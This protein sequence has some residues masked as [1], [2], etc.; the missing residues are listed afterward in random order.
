VTVLAVVAIGVALALGLDVLRYGGPLAWLVAHAPGPAVYEAR[1]RTFDVDGRP[2]YLD[3]R[4]SGSPTVILEAGFGANAGNWSQQLQDIEPLTRVCAWDR[5]G[6][7]RSAPRG[8]HTGLEA[9]ADLRAVLAAAGEHGPYVVVAHSLGGVYGLLFESVE[10]SAGGDGV[11]GFVMLDTF[12]PLAWMAED[13]LLDASIRA[14]H[15]EV[16]AQTGAMIEGGE[17]LDFDATIAEL[18]ALPPTQTETLL[19]PIT[20]DRKFGDQSQPG[21]AALAASWYRVVA[22]HYP[23]GRVEV[24]ADSGHA[25]GADQP[26]LVADR[27]RAMVEAIRSR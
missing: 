10:A 18:L 6:V 8:L 21:P 15:R 20:M 13:P 14:N 11:A 12:E 17:Q 22:E 9:A 16:F 24:V 26:Q 2:I 19:L 1:G 4:G 23:N 5:P 27:V 25:I 7:A 3:C